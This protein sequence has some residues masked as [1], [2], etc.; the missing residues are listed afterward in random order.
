MLDFFIKNRG[1]IASLTL[2]HLWLVG[3]AIGIAVLV[4]VLLGIVVSRNQWLRKSVLGGTN[5]LQ[6]IPSLALFGFLLPAPWLG[7]RA[8]RLAIVALV[9]YAL[10]PIVRNTYTGIAA[11]DPAVKEAAIGMGMTDSELLMQVE[12]PLSA[13][14][15]LAGIRIATV[16]AVGVATIAAAVG[17]GG[18]GELIFRGVAM[19]NN[20]LILAGAIPAALLAIVADVV[21]GAIENRLRVPR[22]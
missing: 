4:G 21:L 5:V 12:L 14:F 17:A 2:E 8:D 11:I 18:L 7:A 15:M 16:T 10:L 19:V 9:L 20:Q 22:K 6:T 1:Q 3:I 13:S